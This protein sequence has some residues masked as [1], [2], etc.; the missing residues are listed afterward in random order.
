[1]GYEGDVFKPVRRSSLPLKVEV[2]SNHNDLKDA[3]IKKRKA[4]DC[5]FNAERG[6][7]WHIRMQGLPGKSLDQ[8]RILYCGRAIKNGL[9]GH[10]TGWR[11]ETYLQAWRRS[12]SRQRWYS[13]LTFLLFDECYFNAFQPKC[14]PMRTISSWTSPFPGCCRKYFLFLIPCHAIVAEDFA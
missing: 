2:S 1:M 11:S 6:Y 13:R 9:E 4:F 5:T 7:V 8:T 3:A 10:I 14:M 12:W